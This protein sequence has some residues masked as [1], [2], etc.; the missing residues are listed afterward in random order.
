MRKLEIT[1]QL[2]TYLERLGYGEKTVEI[3]K[4]CNL[5]FMTRLEIEQ[6]EVI[7]DITSADIIDHY[8]YLNE[9][10]NK[11]THGGLSSKYIDHHIYSLKIFFEWQQTIQSIEENPMSSL[12]FPKGESKPMQVLTQEEIQQLYEVTETW[13]EK[14]LLSIFYGCGLRKSEGES[15]D[16]KDVHFRSGILYVRKGKGSKRRAVPMSKK[17][18]EPIYQ[19]IHEE[20]QNPNQLK[21]L[22]INKKD[23]RMRGQTFG[24]LLGKLMNRTGIKKHI[25]LHCLRHSIATHLLESGMRIEKVK[26]FLGHNHLESTMRYARVSK[27]MTYGIS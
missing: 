5:E 10:P 16:I 9:R 1:H 21:A 24:L 2:E 11:I 13:K 19:Y 22:V 26:D 25:T 6:V 7:Q 17:V 14:T 4:R 18:S 3:V 12:T 8:N 20:R 27:E 23:G 15:L